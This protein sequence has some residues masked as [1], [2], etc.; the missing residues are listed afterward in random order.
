MSERKS[1][2]DKLIG[3]PDEYEVNP[4]LASKAIETIEREQNQPKRSWFSLR[5]KKLSTALASA[6]VVA[7]LGIVLVPRLIPSPDTPPIVYYANEA[8]RVDDLSDMGTFASE[9][10]LQAKYFTLSNTQSKVAMIAETQQIAY[11]QQQTIYIGNGSFDTLQLR[12]VVLQNATFDFEKDYEELSENTT[13]MDMNIFYGVKTG[14]GVEDRPKVLA[15]FE[16]DN[17]KYYLEIQTA[18]DAAEKVQQYVA[19]LLA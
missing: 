17:V 18:G 3:L 13:Y 10:G 4:D 9:K 15:R 12:A 7:A 19:M 11:L 5:W 1:N 6:A 16:K 14:L 2:W 8:V